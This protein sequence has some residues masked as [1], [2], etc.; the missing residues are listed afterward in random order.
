V[1]LVVFLW[2]KCGSHTGK[3]MEMEMEVEIYKDS[4]YDNGK[5]R[6][7]VNII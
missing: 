4:N 1:Q 3:E 7:Y 5:R 6:A 2:S